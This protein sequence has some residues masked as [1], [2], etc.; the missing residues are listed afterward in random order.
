MKT[1]DLLQK[2][3]PHKAESLKHLWHFSAATNLG[4]FFFFWQGGDYQ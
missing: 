1:T 3:L 4:F 2:L